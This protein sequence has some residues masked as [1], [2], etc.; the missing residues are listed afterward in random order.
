[1]FGVLRGLVVVLIGVLLAGMTTLPKAT[2]WRTAMFAPPLETAA[3][4]AKPWLPAEA[5]KRIRFEA[6]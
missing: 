2:W 3:I 6:R 5:A 1:M 4:A